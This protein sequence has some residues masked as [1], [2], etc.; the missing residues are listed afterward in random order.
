M[1]IRIAKAEDIKSL[2]EVTRRCIKNLDDNGIY[3][4]DDIYPSG[5]DFHE[6]IAEQSLYVITDDA[7][8]SISG[9]ICINEVEYPG[10]ENAQ[11][12]GSE[13]FVIHKMIIDPLYE[14]RGH[15]KFAMNFAEKLAASTKRDS[16][17][18]DCFKKNI[19]AN[20]FYQACGYIK[21]GETIFRKGVFNLYEKLV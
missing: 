7:G 9:S 12:S 14:S 2:M 15:G 16:L 17:R 20:R 21:K 13:F 18:L 8:D 11:W 10:Y 1:K 5:K 4:W 6:D 3:Q 19:R